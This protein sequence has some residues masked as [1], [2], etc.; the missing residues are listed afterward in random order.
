MRS[1]SHEDEFST[2]LLRRTDLLD[3]ESP[4]FQPYPLPEIHISFILSRLVKGGRSQISF[5]WRIEMT[6]L[7]A[8]AIL[9]MTLGL[10]TC[11]DDKGKALRANI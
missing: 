11:G 2:C 9:V 5:N 10:I 4:S 8:V 1:S 6:K 7:M 3:R